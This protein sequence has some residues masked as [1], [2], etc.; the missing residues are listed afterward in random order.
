MTSEQ[1]T[2]SYGIPAP[3]TG[4]ARLKSNVRDLCSDLNLLICRPV[5]LLGSRLDSN[6]S[7]LTLAAMLVTRHVRTE[8]RHYVN[9]AEDSGSFRV[10]N[11]TPRL[12][13]V[14][15]TEEIHC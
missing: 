3:Q 11:S 6:E 5:E 1:A 9:L 4:L 12:Q 10:P 14:H 15:F 2:D 13:G 7:A 8:P